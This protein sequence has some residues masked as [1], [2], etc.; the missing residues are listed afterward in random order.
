MK[1]CWEIPGMEEAVQVT[2]LALSRPIDQVLIDD[3]SV[4][5][6]ETEKVLCVREQGE[7]VGYMLLTFPVPGLV[8]IAGTMVIPMLQGTGIKAHATRV[9][10]QA[11]PQIRFWAGRTQS[12]IVW[13][14]VTRAASH[15]LPHPPGSIPSQ[16]WPNAAWPGLSGIHS[17][18]GRIRDVLAGV[19]G[20]SSWLEPGFYGG[21]LYGEKPTHC[22]PAVQAWWDTFI[23]FERGDAVL[24]IAKL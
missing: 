23:D 2:A 14:S 5:F 12:S 3:V 24:Y 7:L 13:A 17:E 22:D 16:P 4:H 18:M 8:Y 11:H 19:L 9:V 1:Y 21:P 15:V 10:M 20:M 6:A